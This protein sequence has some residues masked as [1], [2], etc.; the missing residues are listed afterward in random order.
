M[1]LLVSKVVFLLVLAALAAGLL[2]AAASEVREAAGPAA[3]SPRLTAPPLIRP[4]PR[5][6][7][8]KSAGAHTHPT[9]F[10]TNWHFL[11]DAIT[12]DV[13][14]SAA[15][16][17]DTTNG[18][19][20]LELA[21]GANTRQAAYQSGSGTNKLVFQYR[22]RTDDKDDDGVAIPRKALKLNGGS[23][24]GA[25]G[26]IDF[27]ESIESTYMQNRNNQKVDGSQG[28][29]APEFSETASI[30]AQVYDIGTPIPELTIPAASGGNGPL[31]YRAQFARGSQSGSA[32]LLGSGGAGG[33]GG[34]SG[35]VSGSSSAVV[36]GDWMIYTPPSPGDTHGGKISAAPG[37]G[38]NTFKAPIVGL[39][40]L[41]TITVSD[42]DDDT[43]N[44]TDEDQL[45]FNITVKFNYDSDGNGLIEVSKLSQLDAIRYD[46]NGDGAQGT[47]SDTD[48]A[49]YTAAFPH[50]MPGMGCPDTT[51]DTDTDPG[52]CT[53][54]ELTANLD[55][56]TDDDGETYS[57]SSTGVITG[58]AGDAYYNGGAG[59]NPIGDGA[60]PFTAIFTG[61]DGAGNY[62]T[63][64]NLFINV[65]ATAGSYS[66]LFG[67]I[68]SGGQVKDVGLPNV[69]IVLNRV[70]GN[71]GHSGLGSLAGRNQ[72]TVSGSYATGAV[73]ASFSGAAAL[74][75]R[76]LKSLIN[77]GGL[78]GGNGGTVESSYAAVSVTATG[79]SGRPGKD[80]FRAGG[81][82]GRNAGEIN[83]SYA[84]GPVKLSYG[85]YAGGLV[86]Y[87]NEGE[88][89]ASYAASAVQ[90]SHGRYAGG[91]IGL[92]G[93]PSG[94]ITASYATGLVTVDANTSAAGGLLGGGDP[95]SVNSYW[96]TGTTG[97]SISWGGAGVVGKTTR[98]L[99]TPTGYTGIYANWKLDIDGDTTTG[100][101][102]GKDEIWDFGTG[103]QDP[104]LKD[105]SLNDEQQQQ[106]IKQQRRNF[107]SADNWNAPAVGDL[108]S[109]STDA[110][111]SA[112]WKWQR[113]T[114]GVWSEISN[115]T[116]SSYVPVAAD[117]G[118]R[119]RA[120][121]TYI[122]GGISQT[123]TTANTG[124]VVAVSSVTAGAPAPLP[125][126][127][128]KLRYGLGAVGAT[129]I[130][131][132]HWRRCDDLA[133]TT[134][135]K[136]VTAA[137][138]PNKAHS[139]YTPTAGAGDANDVNKYLQAHVY[140]AANDAA[141]TWTRATTP[142]MG[143]VVA[144][145]ASSSSGPTGS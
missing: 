65:S 52:P 5:T 83:A 30:A 112:T 127:G 108:V 45:S 137:I 131:A 16:T 40:G 18:T 113:E 125:V 135:C 94:R 120:I 80:N 111:A 50:A 89:N 39:C 145:A 121:A 99:Q 61:K 92:G 66:G 58:D 110:P 1:R 107:L 4:Y 14:I 6:P 2:P 67:V 70:L 136:A 59:W 46:L 26:A 8:F 49:K 123:L 53:G 118:Q 138:L 79:R 81:L 95:I 25:G 143:P 85:Y 54:Y 69:K 22:V 35:G 130:Q 97:Q 116:A 62:H 73:S 51:A 41:V 12:V 15:V 105:P 96:D 117:V 122:E 134:N 47:V 72:G 128:E 48:W 36:V 100:D 13:P 104:V 109:V 24:A 34:S 87:N 60:A 126:V 9:E 37:T 106:Q 129:D 75:S 84:V 132:W 114:D 78:L 57:T 44:V 17:V 56:D 7:K 43:N 55:F 93:G 23:I 31:Q 90:V 124:A 102:S 101:A 103:H 21:I 119:L 76:V 38:P 29:S 140:Y 142:V 144:A 71:P 115:A 42:S 19:P 91:L 3:E 20:Y 68:G 86:G 82:A 139:E 74:D 28:K 133:M 77:I 33:A 64:A 141:K 63:I 11:Y 32:C 10:T 98:E 88:I 27:G